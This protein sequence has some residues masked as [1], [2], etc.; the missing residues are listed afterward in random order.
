MWPGRTALGKAIMHLER[1]PAHLGSVCNG[2]AGPQAISRV[3]R[4]QMLRTFVSLLALCLFGARSLAAPFLVP[5]DVN[6]MATNGQATISATAFDIHGAAQI[7]DTDRDSL[8]RTAN[9]NPAFV[10]VTFTTPQHIEAVRVQFT[11]ERHKW[12][13]L[14]GDTPEQLKEIASA[15][16]QGEQPQTVTLPS[17]ASARVFRLE[18]KREEGDNYV[19]IKDWELLR[20]GEVSDLTVSAPSNDVMEDSVLRLAATVKTADGRTLDVTGDTVWAAAA[21]NTEAWR[22]ANEFH[23]TE[24]GEARIAATLGSLSTSLAVPV[25][26]YI[27]SNNDFDLDALYIERTPLLDYDSRPETGGWPKK[28]E[29]VWWVA[30]VKNWGGRDIPEVSYRWVMDGRTVGQGVIK[31]WKAGAETSVSQPWRW[32]KKRHTLT[33]LLDPDSEYMEEASRANNQV[34]IATDALAV[35]YWVEDGLYRYMHEHQRELG[36]GA[37]SFEDWGQRQMNLWNQMFGN[38]KSGTSPRGILDR[39]RLDRV[40][41]VPSGALPLNGGLPTNNPDAKDKTVDLMWGMTAQDMGPGKFWEVKHSGPFYYEYGLIHEL[42]HAR[43]LVDSY[44]FDVHKV[45]VD[46]L[47][48]PDGKPMLGSPAMPYSGGDMVHKDKY[49]GMMDSTHYFSEY[50][51][52]AWNRITGQRARK[53]NQNGPGDIGAYIHEDLPQQNHFQFVDEAGKPLAG[54]TVEIHQAR[55]NKDEWYGKIYIPTPDL[56][57]TTDTNGWVTLPRNPFGEPLEHGYGHAN[58]V[59]LFVVHAGEVTRTAF[60][61]ASDFNLQFYKGQKKDAWYQVIVDLSP[62][63]TTPGKTVL[64]S[65][66]DKRD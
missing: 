66:R 55:P 45:A 19:H 25:K 32:E 43:Y 14:A 53:G 40:I 60:Q 3:W 5:V 12:T 30:H 64:K 17:P 50:E 37:N 1:Q 65:G 46:K 58:T 7:F 56:T 52:Y 24:P 13:V 22:E 16:F 38:A 11:G 8:A 2:A 21:A 20:T 9:I 27:S 41:H 15:T 35:G 51:A 42:D 61:E 44:G 33:F 10:Q 28:G 49:R 54:A 62:G 29:A 48:L 57:Y 47:T 31:D 18:V 36:D 6:A 26:P 4:T 63:N 39:V 59:L 23:V 34:T